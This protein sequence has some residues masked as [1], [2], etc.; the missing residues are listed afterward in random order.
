MPQEIMAGLMIPSLLIAPSP[1]YSQAAVIHCEG[2]FVRN[3][4]VYLNNFRAVFTPRKPRNPL[5]RLGLGLRC[6]QA[7]RDLDCFR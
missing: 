3:P 4:Y 5:L 2:R 7:C 1:G 6:Q